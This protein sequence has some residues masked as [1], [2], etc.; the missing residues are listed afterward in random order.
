VP[1]TAIVALRITATGRQLTRCLLSPYSPG[2]RRRAF[3]A[4]GPMCAVSCR[5]V[6]SRRK[7]PA[8]PLRRHD[9]RAAILC[10]SN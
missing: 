5:S 10:R 2:R 8:E 4:E 3:V 9:E 7:E 6:V 1:T